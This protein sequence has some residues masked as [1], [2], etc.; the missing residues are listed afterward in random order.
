MPYCQEHNKQFCRDCNVGF[1]E[2]GRRKYR[3]VEC[4]GVSICEHGRQNH[5]CKECNDPIPITIR[6]MI[7]GAKRN[8]IRHNRYD[9]P[10]LVDTDF[11]R[12]LIEDSETC[13]YCECILQ[14]RLYQSNLG[15]LE[16]IDNTLGHIKTNCKIACLTCNVS[17]VGQR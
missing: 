10:N 15:T 6:A 1:C 17:K 14:Y 16:R 5:H 2:H 3:C 8:D 12:H 4:G 9:L 13:C 11:V 7:G